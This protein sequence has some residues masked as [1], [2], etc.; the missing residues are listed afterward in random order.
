VKALQ[1][2]AVRDL[3]H[4]RGQA[5]AIALVIAGGIA[6]LVMAQSTYQSLEG[7]RARFYGE[8]AL[9]D[10]WAS[11]KRAPNPLAGRIAAIAGVQTV[12]TRLVAPATLAVAGFDEPVRAQ[13]LSL[14]KYG[15][16][17][18]L[19]RI[20]LRSGRL[21]D[22]QAAR[23]ALVSE[24]FAEAH[25]LRAGD[26]LEAT[27]Y[28]HRQR[29]DI[30]GIAISPEFVYQIQPG[31]T[32]PDFLRF[33]ILWMNTR[34][35]EAALDM[36]D[37]FNS[38]TLRLRPGADAQAV[39]DALDAILA[40]YGGL[41]AY[42][43]KDQVSNRFL[44]EELRQLAT[45]ARLFPTIFL[46]VA[47]FLLNVVLARLIGM[48]RDQIAILKAF[49]YSGA[50][51]ALHYVQIALLIAGVGAVIGVAGGAWLGHLLAGVYRDFYRF[52]FLDYRLSALALATGVGVA[53]T[54]ATLGALQSAT[55]SA[56]LPPAEAMRP[57][58]PERYRPALF[59]RLG[60]ARTLSQP[61]RMVLRY[62]ERRPWK[63]VL[64]VIGLALAVAI[65][66]VGRFQGD[67][68][69]RMI[70]TQ[71]RVAE[72]QDLSVDF[73]EPTAR[74]AID[75]LRALPLVRRAEPVRS[76]SVRLRFANYSYRTGITGLAADASLRRPVAADGR[77]IVAPRHGILLTDYLAKL[78]HIGVGDRVQ[79]DV[80]EGRQVRTE[81]PV[82][83]FVNE[84]IGA[85]G[86]MDLDAL[87]RVL[88]DGDV[89]SGALLAL[90][91]GDRAP[92]FAKLDER[93]RVAGIGSREAQI[94]SFY[95]TMGESLLFFTFIA[96]LLGAVIN[97]GVVYNSARIALSERGRELASLRVLGFTR[98]EVSRILLG[99]LG[100][101]VSLSIPLGFAAG[102][103]L[104]W[105]MAIGFE[106]D[107]FRVPVTLLP[108]TYAFAAVTMAVSTVL[109]ALIVR[110][111]IDRLDL[112]GVLKTRE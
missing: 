94:R 39:L 91:P 37:A 18:L 71:L 84:Y 1:R 110:R 38:V 29:L 50:T 47:A 85:Q 25:G 35:L 9:A 8:Y 14:P 89:I 22:P 34:A 65:M 63:A 82:A 58:A 21:P 101:L 74:Q 52:P 3:F 72:H 7:T 108:A 45:M 75:E 13:V 24:A 46:G 33:G 5:L 86:Y 17:P 76:V 15:G 67:A 10:V 100:L 36:T 79:V 107:L 81:L 93:P 64:S 106:S 59:E 56:R 112:I 61:A 48:Q 62:L 53:F 92:L 43:R 6:T 16:Q 49:G 32:F 23:E 87:N 68:L 55:R 60:F 105:V 11:A 109:S 20:Y 42:A 73:I 66:M 103:S 30:V 78:L 51:I 41:G 2:K 95:T 77:A 57:P 83:G 69:E 102:W 111:R 96:G 44:S 99:E 26:H 70:D 97:F 40:R 80:L 88:G 12:Q 104:C 31:A 19:N 28:G 27:I 90:E 54:A 98:A 4:L